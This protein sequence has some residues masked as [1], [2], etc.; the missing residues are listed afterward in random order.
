MQKW[1]ELLWRSAGLQLGSS[2]CFTLSNLAPDCCCLFLLVVVFDTTARTEEVD[3]GWNSFCDQIGAEFR[4][5]ACYENNQL[6][7]KEGCEEFDLENIDCDIPL[8]EAPEDDEFLRAL[9]SSR[10]AADKAAME[11]EELKEDAGGEGAA[12]AGPCAAEV[13][14]GEGDRAAEPCA[15]ETWKGGARGF[16]PAPAPGSPKATEVLPA[17]ADRPRPSSEE[18]AKSPS[19]AAAKPGPPVQAKSS[20]AYDPGVGRK[21][22]PPPKQ[23]ARP[24]PPPAAPP[25]L[26]PAAPD[27]SDG[28]KAFLTQMFE[29]QT[30]SMADKLDSFKAETRTIVQD[31]VAPVKASMQKVTKDMEEIK[32]KQLEQEKAII[33]LQDQNQNPM[34][35]APGVSTRAGTSGPPSEAGSRRSV[36]NIDWNIVRPEHSPGW[37]L[38]KGWASGDPRQVIGRTNRNLPCDNT[39]ET[40]AVLLN[41]ISGHRET[42]S[43][44]I[45]DRL[46]T[47]GANHRRDGVYQI[48]I[49]FNSGVSKNTV[50]EV[51][52]EWWDAIKNKD[53]RLRKEECLGARLDQRLTLEVENPPWKEPQVKAGKKLAAIFHSLK[54]VATAQCRIEHG[55]STLSWAYVRPQMPRTHE[56]CFGVW[57]RGDGWKLTASELAKVDNAIS[58]EELQAKSNRSE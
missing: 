10:M 3:D 45:F 1:L 43:V 17:G 34:S 20:S 44:K 36:N 54:Q 25:G 18:Q 48:K 28:L 30:K 51:R 12:G 35:V 38:L 29:N 52:S 13:A 41:E 27:G 37:I 14:G 40:V 46:A 5:A 22:P 58:A 6:I 16:R 32:R 55:G 33:K 4:T 31:E 49:F 53:E 56:V 50:W 9:H 7:R 24:P 15:G 11:V 57:T 39:E 23:E 2:Y 42:E 19:A 8:E 21:P 47:S 26:Q